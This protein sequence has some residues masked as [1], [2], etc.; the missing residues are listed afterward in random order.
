MESLGLIATDTPAYQHKTAI[1]NHVSIWHSRH[2]VYS[3]VLLIH[4]TQ[5]KVESLQEDVSG[6]AGL[7]QL[8]CLSSRRGVGINLK[9]NRLEVFFRK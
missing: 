5:H 8:V 7:R 4:T 2:L 1:V 3:L 6:Y 9:R